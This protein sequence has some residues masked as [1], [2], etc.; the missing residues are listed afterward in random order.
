MRISETLRMRFG[1]GSTMKRRRLRRWLRTRRQSRNHCQRQ[2]GAED[3]FPGC[4]Q[5]QLTHIVRHDNGNQGQT[6]TMLHERFNPDHQVWVW[7]RIRRGR[8]RCWSWRLGR[9]YSVSRP[10][11][12]F[13]GKSWWPI[14]ITL[15]AEV[16]FSF[17]E[18][19]RN[20]SLV[21]RLLHWRWKI[22]F[23][24][25]SKSGPK[26]TQKLEIPP[27]KNFDQMN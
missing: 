7:W 18:K 14:I 27:I 4:S 2:W 16:N 24:Q 23:L 21:H 3:W 5:S 19:A 6:L 1:R 10:K 11:F 15:M 12:A 25:I 22:K 9:N 13:P 8:P 20:C 26:L 17:P